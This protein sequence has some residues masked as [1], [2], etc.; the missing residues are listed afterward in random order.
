MIP[1]CLTLNNIRYVSRV[2]W[3]NPGKGVASSPTPRCYGYWKG[4]LR[5]GLDYGRQLFYLSFLSSNWA[6]TLLKQPK[7]FIE[8]KVKKFRSSCK[9]IDYQARSRNSKT[10]DSEAV[11]QTI[12]TSSVSNSESIRWAWHLTIKCHLHE[13]S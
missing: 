7:T 12:E 4:S 3:S 8:Q 9:N 1:P 10:A 13:L 2:K 5:V 11:L 6:I